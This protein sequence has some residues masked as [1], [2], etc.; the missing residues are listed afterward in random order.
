ML[1]THGEPGRSHVVAGGRLRLNIP[2]TVRLRAEAEGFESRTLSPFF[3]HPELIR[4]VTQLDAEALLDWK[5]YERVRAHLGEV[6]LTFRLRRAP[7]R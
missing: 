6:P 2:A 7:S 3:D 1:G 4:E 5:T